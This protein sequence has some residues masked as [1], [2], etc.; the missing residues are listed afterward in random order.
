MQFMKFGFFVFTL[1]H[2]K[3]EISD[4]ASHF[5]IVMY[6]VY[7]GQNHN[8]KVINE[9]HIYKTKLNT[10]YDKQSRFFFNTQSILYKGS[11][12]NTHLH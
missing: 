9:I 3:H 10:V 6:F 12:F 8:W 2:F 7:E 4:N 11:A 1:S 5:Y